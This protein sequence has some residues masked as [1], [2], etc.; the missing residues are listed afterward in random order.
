MKIDRSKRFVFWMLLLLF[1]G[2]SAGRI[3]YFPL[4]V[5]RLYRAVPPSALLI[6]E[7]DALAERWNDLSNHPA[8]DGMLRGVHD[9]PV[10]SLGDI[11]Y[12]GMVLDRFGTRKTVFAFCS[13]LGRDR[14]P[15]WIVASWAGARTQFLRWGFYAGFLRDFRRVALPDG[16]GGWLLEGVEGPTGREGLCLTVVDGI[17][18]GCL[19]RDP[20]AIQEIVDRIESRVP[21]IPELAER[22]RT[23]PPD[24]KHDD[25]ANRIYWAT[26]ATHWR[27]DIRLDKDGSAEGWF[28]G[29]CPSRFWLARA[30]GGDGSTEHRGTGSG[31]GFSVMGRIM[32]ES[33]AGVAVVPRLSLSGCLREVVLPPK[34]SVPLTILEKGLDAD[35]PAVIGVCT[36]DYSGRILG[37]KT[38]T[39]L[40]GFK[41]REPDV[42]PALIADFL[43]ALNVRLGTALIPKT[44]PGAPYSVIGVEGVGNGIY[45]RLA[46]N[47]VPAFA[48]VDGWM[49]LCSNRGTLARLIEERYPNPGQGDPRWV[50]TLSG[51]DAHASLWLDLAATDQA[52]SKGLAVYDLM[53]YA[54][55]GGRS[56]GVVRRRFQVVKDLVAALRPLESGAVF[57]KVDGDACHG[58][59][60]VG[61]PS[62]PTTVSA[63]EPVVTSLP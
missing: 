49:I 51:E 59:F 58:H 39:V 35:A 63:V 34:W 31:D 2:L 25:I 27:C 13:R 32:G 5:E 50:H 33:S 45:D 19:S 38:P 56:G 10:R 7:H 16:R 15:A 14:S 3:L 41:L 60:R 37:F 28:D 29:P 6:S 18:V 21:L 48:V 44:D 57:V 30:L 61:P 22:L 17:L 12:A 4:N 55:T 1:V 8:V 11:P 62:K 20:M 46:M 40:I 26:G 36:P 47:E 52:L 23:D 43:D 42:A 9:A 24:G 54:R 53:S